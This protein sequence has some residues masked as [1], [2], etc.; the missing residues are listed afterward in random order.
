M[1][2]D[3]AL[4]YTYASWGKLFRVQ[5]I[6]GKSLRPLLAEALTVG[7]ARSNWTRVLIRLGDEH[8][9]RDVAVGLDHECRCI[10]HRHFRPS[11]LKALAEMNASQALHSL[12]LKFAQVFTVQTAHTAV[13][14][15]RAHIDQRLA[16]WILMAHD[17][18][19]DK[20]IPLTHE[21]L[22]LMLGVRR[23]GVI[24]A[25]QNLKRNTLIDT[26]RNQI[27]V[28]NRKGLERKAGSSYGVPEKEYR[29]LIG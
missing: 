10:E 21:F 17:R 7:S 5:L 1:A 9:V 24:D 22:S 11:R 12:L 27:V 18:T 25:L 2:P 26:G 20:T 8:A 29:R 14:N 16:R 19:G 6:Q 13:A 15:A 3:Y 23:A 4:A 28:R